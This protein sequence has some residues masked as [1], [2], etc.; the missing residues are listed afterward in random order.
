MT[1]WVV[2]GANRGIGLELCRRVHGRG[3]D[4]VAACRLASPELV[5]LGCRVAEGVDVSRD[6]VGV[7]LDR[8][9][10][11]KAVDVLVC[12]AGILRRDGLDALD[13]EGARAQFDVNALGPLRVI[14][15]LLPRLGSGSKVGLV[16]SKAGS[17]GDGP[18]GGNYGYRMSKAAL[19]MA[20]ANLAHELAPR[21]ISVVVLHPGYVRTGMTNGAGT[22]AAAEA[23]AGLVARIDELD[24]GRSGRF[25]H[26]NGDEIPW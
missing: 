22:V 17:I 13:L 12:N 11:G 25:V 20:G 24:V 2:T 14:S 23:A 9:L 15:A 10:G 26:A 7:A 8:A 21:G 16:S 19:D 1:T 3:E 5:A 6:D 18:T 4:V